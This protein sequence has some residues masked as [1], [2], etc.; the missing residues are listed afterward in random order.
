[1]NDLARTLDLSW[2][3]T[4]AIKVGMMHAVWA[5]AQPHKVA[6]YELNGRKRTFRELNANANRVARLLRRA[7]LKPGDGVALI[8]TNRVEFCDVLSGVMRD[9][10]AH[11]A[12]QLAPD[13]RGDRL[14]RCRIAGPRR[15]SPTPGIARRPRA[16]A[17]QCPD[18]RL[19]VAIG[20]EMAGF[21]DYDDGAWRRSTRGGHRRTR[22]AATR[23]STP[24]ARPGGRKGCSSPVLRRRYSRPSADRDRELHLCTGP[25]Y[26][27]APLVGDVR[28]AADQRRAAGVPGQVGQRKVLETI[29]RM[30]VTHTHFVPIMFQRL[31]ALP[32]EERGAYDLRSL[33]PGHPWRCALPAGDQTLHDRVAG[34]G[35]PRILCGIGRRRR[36]RDHLGGVADASPAAS[37]AGQPGGGAH[38]GRARKRAPD[39][40]RRHDLSAPARNGGLRLPQRSGEDRGQP[41]GRLLY[42]GRRRLFR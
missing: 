28:G 2:R 40:R 37:G 10:H 27:A 16:A 33:T 14:Y 25:A 8:C 17:A 23:C 34:A 35:A 36:H 11:H 32:A 39:R 42:D 21:L 4:E 38:P 12:G 1:M 19:K 18:L 22:C 5:Q 31:L 13:R 41:E 9:R 30:G 7:G 6:V 24:R 26:H 29:E 15:C 3:V 20:G